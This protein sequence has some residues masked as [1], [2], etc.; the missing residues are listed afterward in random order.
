MLGVGVGL[1]KVIGENLSAPVELLLTI[2]G[3][4]AALALVVAAPGLLA[5]GPRVLSVEGYSLQHLVMHTR[6]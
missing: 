3:A 5:F 6:I 1:G 4:L 2:A